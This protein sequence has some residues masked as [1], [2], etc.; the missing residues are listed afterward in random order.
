[1]GSCGNPCG[2]ENDGSTALAIYHLSHRP[3]GR[4]THAPGSAAAHARYIMREDAMSALVA[5]LP[6][7]I[8]E[9]RTAIQMWLRDAERADRVNARVVDK[10]VVAL[11]RELDAAGRRELVRDF[12]EDVTGGRMP[13]VAAIHDKGEDAE[14]PHAHV[15]LRDRDLETG[16]R[17]LQTTERGS[18]E[19]LR[20]AWEVAANRALERAGVA[21]RIDRRSLA[22]QGIEREPTRH[23]G[24]HVE[25]MDRKGMNPERLR[26]ARAVEEYN[27]RADAARD[28]RRELEKAREAE[29]ASERGRARV[30]LEQPASERPAAFG[31][32]APDRSKWRAYRARVLSEA[33]HREMADSPLARFWRIERTEQ[34]LKFS[35]ARGSFVDRG[36]RIVTAEANAQ[37]IAA[38]LDVATAKGWSQVR[39]LG[40]DDFKRQG[41]AA[42]LDRGFKVAAAG[43]DAEVLAEVTRERAGRAQARERSQKPMER[44]MPGSPMTV[45]ERAA[46]DGPQPV[47][48]ADVRAALERAERE[49]GVAIDA[50]NME[51]KALG[52]DAERGYPPAL[53]VAQRE[54][55]GR[56]FAEA[57]EA[58]IAARERLAAVQERVAAYNATVGGRG[59]VASALKAFGDVRAGLELRK[60]RAAA[61]AGDEAART[62]LGAVLERL[63][64]PA[65]AKRVAA[66]ARAIESLRES[67]DTQ[68]ASAGAAWR[69]LQGL[70]VRA[71]GLDDR[72]T[73]EAP[74]DLKGLARDPQLRER[75]SKQLEGLM[76]IEREPKSPQRERKGPERD[77]HDR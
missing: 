69:E 49:V 21:E 63:K 58:S 15:M 3:I 2:N 48:L 31:V 19:R 9:T 17:V 20:E 46:P 34:G 76:P 37:V 74:G 40:S 12:C 10:L 26:D 7:G 14:N 44:A 38:M 35:N 65:I 1:M 8:A 72:R 28:A 36:D 39:L 22:A 56:E 51:R 42:A 13:Y 62:R 25:A 29:R 43:R 16:K 59:I 53:E 68:R 77:F 67:A 30:G 47:R 54:V 71:G 27:R 6:E 23:I 11:P 61:L 24:P 33:Y 64:E 18:T 32:E 66:R 70:R 41:M 50:A 60:E 4:S 57:R 5:R 52:Y 75:L 55:G 45:P 73:I